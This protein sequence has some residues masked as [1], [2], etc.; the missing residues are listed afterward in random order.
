[1]PS[2]Q[3]TW[4]GERSASA[5]TWACP[6]SGQGA[7]WVVSLGIEGHVA[8][9]CP[10]ERGRLAPGLRASRRP[11]EKFRVCF[12]VVPVSVP[13]PECFVGGFFVCFFLE[14]FN[15]CVQ[16]QGSG[17]PREGPLWVT[18]FV[19]CAG[20]WWALG[21]LEP[22][23]SGRFSGDFCS[24]LCYHVCCLASIPFSWL[25][26]FFMKRPCL[27]TPL[28]LLLGSQPC[29]ASSDISLAASLLMPYSKVLVPRDPPWPVPSGRLTAPGLPQVRARLSIFGSACSSSSGSVGQLGLSLTL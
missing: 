21:R 11:L 13:F 12:F 28:F 3:E 4:E 2:S 5:D 14:D 17:F 19:D 7:L 24:F 18:L 22:L 15:M 27:S 10:S 1:M 25:E 9:D 16:P 29:R 20:H 26:A 6:S 8:S 23:S